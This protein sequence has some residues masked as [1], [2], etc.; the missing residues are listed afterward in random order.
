MYALKSNVS[1]VNP[2]SCVQE[3]FDLH[4]T[5]FFNLI[6]ASDYD[7]PRSGGKYV[8]SLE[9]HVHV[10]SGERLQNDSLQGVD[11][12]LGVFIGLCQIMP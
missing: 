6:T 5:L 9:D 10:Y 2:W 8:A 1:H 3:Q 12:L 4:T 7:Y 11:L